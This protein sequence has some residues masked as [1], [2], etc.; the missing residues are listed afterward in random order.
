M[1]DG[2]MY[3]THGAGSAMATHIVAETMRRYFADRAEFLGDP[4]FTKIPLKGL[5]DPAYLAS[6]R[7]SIDPARATPSDALNHGAPAVPESLETTHFNIVDQQG[8]AVSFTYT[9]NGSYGSGVTVPR[10][11][12]LLNNEMDGFPS[13]PGEPNMFGLVQ[14]EANAIQ[15]GK[16]PLSAMTPTIVLRDGKLYLVLGAPGGPRIISGVTQVILNVID[17]KMT[18]QEAID[19]PRFHH[20]WKPD[21]LYLEKGFSPDTK[22]LLRRRGHELEEIATV[23][24]VEAILIDSG[25]LQG[26]Q[27][28]RS[29]G[30]AARY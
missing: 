17:F 5:L 11:G 15:P 9:L 27:N 24:A 3:E 1:L 8:N 10:L 25:W 2:S 23:S 28:G 14:G 18:V 6:R 4:D 30:K 21:K 29:A 13:K 12:F 7:A 20:Q 16:R 26:A 19:Q 22:L